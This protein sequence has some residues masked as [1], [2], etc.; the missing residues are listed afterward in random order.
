MDAAWHP[1][2]LSGDIEPATSAGFKLFGQEL[3]VWRDDKGTAHVWEDRCPHRGMRLSFG[4]VR[5]NHLACLYHGW[6]YDRSGQCRHIPAHPDLEVPPTITVPVYKARE[7]AGIIWT[8]LDHDAAP[9]EEIAG[10][11]AVAVRSVYLDKPVATAIAALV[12]NGLDDG[13]AVRQ[14]GQNLCLV[15]SAT[16]QLLAAFQPVS[17]TRTGMH[18]VALDVAP[19]K[20]LKDLARIVEAFRDSLSGEVRVG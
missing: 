10:I 4:F 8:S 11:P 1:V 5:G 3:V 13:D 2:A 20:P 17:E 6:Q 16:S 7:W 12:A 15:K 14:L 9:G 18:V 19:D